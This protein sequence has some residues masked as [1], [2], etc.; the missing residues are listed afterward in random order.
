[1]ACA[2]GMEQEQKFHQLFPRVAAW[3]IAGETLQLLDGA[4]AVLA[5]FESRYLK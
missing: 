4:G 3:K 2:N 5:T 1:M